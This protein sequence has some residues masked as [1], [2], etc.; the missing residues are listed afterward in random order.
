MKNVTVFIISILIFTLGF[1]QKIDDHWVKFD[2]IRLPLKPL[3][4]SV[5]TY[6]SKIISWEDKAALE[7][8]A[9]YE[10]ELEVYRESYNTAQAQYKKE[11]E[12]Y[13]KK[14][15]LE[16]VI[17]KELLEENKPV[18][19]PPPY[20]DFK[21]LPKSLDLENLASKYLSLD[22]YEKGTYNP[23]F[24]TVQLKDFEKKE[25]TSKS[26][27]TGEGENTKTTTTYSTKYK[28]PVKLTVESA[29]NGILYDDVLPVSTEYYTYVSKSSPTFDEVKQFA[30]NDLLSYTGKYLDNNYGKTKMNLKTSVVLIKKFKKYTYNEHEEALPYALSGYKNMYLDPAKSISSFNKAINIWEKV[31]EEYNPNNKKAR[32]NREV[33]FYTMLNIG[34]AYMWIDNYEK[35]DEYFSRMEATMPDWRNNKRL[36]DSKNRL[37]D[38]KERFLINQR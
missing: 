11:L 22:G 5:K 1:S 35:A 23:V 8:Q 6:Q 10:A 26:K 27:T 19:N 16:K 32:V 29:I 2:Y 30:T 13:N 36:K 33:A 38:R 25:T 7:M 12:E 34:E 9:Q 3:D 20:P 24:I 17:D 28:I 31:L 14:T 37:Q 21:G 4:R 15:R 18:F